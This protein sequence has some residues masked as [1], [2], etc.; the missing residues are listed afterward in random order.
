[1]HRFKNDPEWGALL[2]RFRDGKMTDDDI[3]LINERVV[4]PNTQL[5]EDIKYATYYNRDRDSINT[6]LFEERCKHLFQTTGHVADSLLV[7]SDNITVE[8]GS[9]V[10]V[11]LQNQTSFWTNCG[12][13]D[14]KLPRGSGRMDPL[15]KL[16]RGC[17]LML[18]SNSNVK[19]G[20]AN[21]T[22]VTVEKV[23][24]KAG[25]Q[26]KEILLDGTIP[27]ASVSASQISY[28]VLL[29]SNTRIVPPT[30]SLRPKQHTFKA[31]ILKPQSLQVRGKERELIRMKA[32]Q[33]P[34]I[35]NNATTG[36]KLQ[37]SGVDTL[38]VHNWSY[39]T[40]WVYV[41]L[42]RVKTRDGLF[43]RKPLST[44][45][46]KYKVAPALLTMQRAAPTYCSP[47]EYNDLLHGDLS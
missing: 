18:P 20:Q 23:V 40:N 8:N 12:E 19:E 22:Q 34:V 13:D 45:V 42:S 28:I 24:L 9:G 39:V 1:M 25:E 47:E 30:F 38:F 33:L 26:P 43:C 15:L 29:H 5:P 3:R 17:R 41:M 4:A 46:N 21:G 14:I 2:L 11:P 37:G 16:Y 44:D 27:I 31:N 10:F 35:V 36:H 6:A 32:T 7:F